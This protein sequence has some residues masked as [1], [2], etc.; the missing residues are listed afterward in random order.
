MCN[1]EVLLGSRRKP[2]EGNRKQQKR[3]IVGD[4]YVYDYSL[5]Q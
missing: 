2:M 3:N 1:L 4:E 5:N